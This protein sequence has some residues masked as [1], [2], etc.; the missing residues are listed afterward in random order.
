MSFTPTPSKSYCL[1]ISKG[2]VSTHLPFSIYEPLAE[3]SLKLISG[4]KL[5]AKG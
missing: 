4:L 1:F 5:V 3:T 2:L